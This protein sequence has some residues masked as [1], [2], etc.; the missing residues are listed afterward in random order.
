MESKAGSDISPISFI[1]P[2][3]AS[4]F[5]PKSTNNQYSEFDFVRASSPYGASKLASEQYCFAYHKCF[6]MDIKII[7]YFSVYGPGMNKF[8]I[9]DLI[10][11][12]K[13]NPKELEIKGDGNQV[14]DYLYIDDAIDALLFIAELGKPGEDYNVGSGEPI[15]ILELAKIIAFEMGVPNIKITTTNKFRLGDTQWFSNNSKVRSLGYIPK[16][17]LHTGIKKTIHWIENNQN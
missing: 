15:T 13:K 5:F 4:V 7:R 9:Y 16:I 11:K 14:R 8:V 10:N 3:S 12:I 17:P 2:S 6:G 1:F